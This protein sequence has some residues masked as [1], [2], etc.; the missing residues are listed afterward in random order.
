[1]MNGSD[2]ELDFLFAEY[3]ATVEV[4]EAGT[5]FMPKL[6]ERIESRR[7]FAFQWKRVTQVFVGSAAVICLFITG[8]LVVPRSAAALNHATYLDVLAE[9]HPTENL[10]AQGIAR[11][12]IPESNR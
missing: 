11:Y 2:R 8:M 12:D 7:G 10:A 9:A 6:W 3:R 5:H 4:P 1:M